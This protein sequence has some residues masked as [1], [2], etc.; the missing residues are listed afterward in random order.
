MTE[1]RRQ[2][3]SRVARRDHECGHDEVARGV[4]DRIG[5]LAQGTLQI[6]VPKTRNET[7]NGFF[8]RT[9]AVVAGGQDRLFESA[10][11]CDGITEI[12]GPRCNRLHEAPLL[13]IV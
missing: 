13:C 9:G 1:K 12:L 2:I 3:T 10:R 11:G 8:D 4:V 5:E 7:C 6:A